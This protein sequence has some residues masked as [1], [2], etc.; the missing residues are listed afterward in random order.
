LDRGDFSNGVELMT[1]DTPHLTH[2]DSDGHVRMVDVT[3]KTPTARMARAEAIVRISPEL[4][5]R[6]RAGTLA[7]GPVEEVIRIAAICAAKRTDEL[8]PLCHTLPLDGVD[9]CTT[10]AD[11]HVR[12]EVR[13]CTFARTGVE[14]EA[15]VA[16]SIGALALIDMGKAVDRW[17]VIERVR[18]LEKR[19]GRSGTHLAADA[20]E[21]AQ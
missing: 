13:V 6:I 15:L 17:M 9:V 4:A 20:K 12:I 2:V 5:S 8:I 11:D 3:A 21:F 16:A 10:V 18:M 1:R 19:G 7:K 14:M